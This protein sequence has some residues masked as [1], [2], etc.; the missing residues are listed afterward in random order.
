[1]HPVGHGAGWSSSQM[2][3]LLMI[4]SL[5]SGYLYA[6]FRRRRAGRTWSRWRTCLF[7]IGCLLL[8][9]SWL[10]RLVE[11][12]HQDFRGH[13]AQHLLLGMLAPLGLVLGAPVTLLLASLPRGAARLCTSWL[14]SPLVRTVSHPISTLI[15]NL[16]G[17]YL[18]YMTPLYPA[19]LYNPGL[20]LLIHLHFLVAGC[21]FTWSIAGPDPGPRRPAWRFRLVILF[22][23]MAGHAILAKLMY[24]YGWPQGTQ[25][26]RDQIQTG[27]ELMYYGGD[28]AEILLLVALLLS[29]KQPR[30]LPQLLR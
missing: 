10:P 2:I 17:M 20:H 3:I 5:W 21:L 9:A 24:G 19:S 26:S 1:M 23:S 18:L 4:L 7:S 30:Q 13:M 29:W 22:L 6:V 16:G 27:A 25:F 8:A 28:I 12:A 15:L 11:F 14:R